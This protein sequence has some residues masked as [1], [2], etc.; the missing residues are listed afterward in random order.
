MLYRVCLFLESHIA[1]GGLL[2][3]GVS[4]LLVLSGISPLYFLNVGYVLL[5]TVGWPFCSFV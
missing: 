5:S 1:D 3:Q 4:L 2:K